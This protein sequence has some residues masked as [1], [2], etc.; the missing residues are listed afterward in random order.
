MAKVGR[1]REYKTAKALRKGV[2]EYFDSISYER[3]LPGAPGNM[4]ERVWVK[5]PSMAGLYL[6]LGIGKS[7]WARYGEDDAL[8]PVVEQ[9]RMVMEDYWAGQLSGKFANGAKFAL[10]AC[11]GWREK[12]DVAGDGLVQVRLSGNAEEAAE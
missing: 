5:A 3:D 1:P 9:A 2:E 10:S 12:V 8:G 6:H 4:T 7:T 11:Y